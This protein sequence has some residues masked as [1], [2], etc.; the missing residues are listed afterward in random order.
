MGSSLTKRDKAI[1]HPQLM[2]KIT[3]YAG[4]L[5]PAGKWY[6]SKGYN[7]Y[8]DGKC[9]HFD[10]ARLLED[11]GNSVYTHE[12]THNS[13]G[14]IYFEGYARREDQGMPRTL[15]IRRAQMNQLLRSILS[16]QDK[17]SK[18]RMHT[19]TLKGTCSDRPATSWPWYV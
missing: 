14:A 17:D 4:I 13:D 11:Y 2:T 3:G 10:R 5:G 7:A 9:Y 8:A 16:S 1:G 18:T 12:M 6:P 15:A 19:Y